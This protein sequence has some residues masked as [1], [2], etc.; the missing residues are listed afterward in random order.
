VADRAGHAVV[1]MRKNFLF[2]GRAPRS[3]PG[4]GELLQ[5]EHTQTAPFVDEG[6]VSNHF[7]V[8]LKLRIR[9]TEVNHVLFM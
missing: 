2:Y 5:G 7:A 9:Q 4:S 1:T 6:M 3:L 8:A